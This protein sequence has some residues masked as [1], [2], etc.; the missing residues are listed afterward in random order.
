MLKKLPPNLEKFE[1]YEIKQWYISKIPV[2]RVRKSGEDYYLTVKSQGHV[3]RIEH[4]L[5]LDKTEFENLVKISATHPI[6]KRR[7]L[8][9]IHN[10]LTAELDVFHSEP[11]KNLK[12]VEVEFKS[13]EEAKEFY[14]PEWFG[15]EVS[16][17]PQYKNAVMALDKKD[18]N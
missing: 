16:F 1:S 3:S 9:P 12:M 2:I 10:D 17:D 18:S 5:K 14:P 8:I 11:Y 6:E 4:E 13:E 7:Y 15:S